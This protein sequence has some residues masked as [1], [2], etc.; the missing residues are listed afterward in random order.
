MFKNES[1]ILTEWFNHY[2]SQGVDH[3]YLIDNGSTDTYTYPETKVTLIK[4]DTRYPEN[5]QNILMNK[6]YLKKVRNETEWILICDIDEYVYA[7]RQYHTIPQ[8]LQ[9]LP[10]TIQKIWIPWK[11]FGSNKNVK[12]PSSVINGFVRRHPLQQHAL[13]KVNGR[14]EKI[15]GTGKMISRAKHVYELMIHETLTDD[16]TIYTSHGIPYTSPSDPET[17]PLHLNHYMLMSRE[18]YEKIKCSRGGGQSG[19]IYKYTMKYFDE[20]DPHCKIL[21][22]ELKHI[23]NRNKTCIIK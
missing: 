22:E 18:Y 2:L 15:L 13:Q 11:V 7:R 17:Y 21:D 9:S 19:H 16:N 23:T 4:D 14:I 1:W 12:Q 6:H 8:V 10:S 3:F 20:L 5:T